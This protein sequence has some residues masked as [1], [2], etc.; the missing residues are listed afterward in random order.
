MNVVAVISPSFSIIGVV[1]LLSLSVV[2][3]N[4]A[5]KNLNKTTF[6][7]SCKM[8]TDFFR[9]YRYSFYFLNFGI[10]SSRKEN[11]PIM[12]FSSIFNSSLS[13]IS[14]NFAYSVSATI[15]MILTPY[16]CQF[17]VK[18]DRVCV[19]PAK[20]QMGTT[21]DK[22]KIENSRAAAAIS[23]E[24]RS[25]NRHVCR[26]LSDFPTSLSLSSKNPR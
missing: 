20:K 19:L 12:N 22:Y 26:M 2:L 24:L 4:S 25:I 8:K 16:L 17:T 11:I 9:L 10:F 13:S 21:I 6:N 23:R 1:A 3:N 18:L 15:P 7:P 14:W 5:C